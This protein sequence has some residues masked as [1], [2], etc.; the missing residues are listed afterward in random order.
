MLANYFAFLDSAFRYDCAQCGQACCRGK[1]VALSAPA[2]LAK[3][4]VR[5]P[6]VA[7]LLQPL[8]G[9]YT[10]LPDVT[11]G[12]WFLADDGMCDYER[13]FGRAAK[14]ATCRLFPFNRVFRVGNVRVVDVNSVI[15]PLQDAL[16]TGQGARHA[17]LLQEL[18][19]IGNN[20]LLETQLE[21]PGLHWLPLETQLLVDSERFVLAATYDDF[22]QH[23]MH[24]TAQQLGGTE[25]RPPLAKTAAL[26]EL[27]YG[28]SNGPFAAQVARALTL[29]TPSLRFNALFRKN[30]LAYPQLVALLPAS[31]LSTF[32]LGV[33]ACRASNRAL[34]LRGLTE[35]HQATADLRLLLS[36]LHERAH[37]VAPLVCPD[38]PDPWPDLARRL[39]DRLDARKKGPPLAEVLSEAAQTLPPESR[40]LLPAVFLRCKDSL[41]WAALTPTRRGLSSGA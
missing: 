41:R 17:E 39:S 4:M 28:P 9:G 3:L 33:C 24:T 32:V 35:L 15:C 40:A 18:D 25:P 12:C 37:L 19:D 26:L 31:L 27:F 16:G 38:L 5:A 7:P 23:M 20:P 29:L 11:D 30:A 21:P 2:E 13:T 14:F 6:Q 1:S 22:A 36:R 10:R 8:P 34:S